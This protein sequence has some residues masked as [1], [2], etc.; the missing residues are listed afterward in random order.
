M[1]IYTCTRTNTS[2]LSPRALCTN[3]KHSSSAQR[4]ASHPIGTHRRS[5]ARSLFVPRPERALDCRARIIALKMAAR[6]VSIH[7]TGE[8]FFML[9]YVL[10][11]A[12]CDAL[13]FF[14][15]RLH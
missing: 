11:A 15:V 12:I 8:M 1:E 10:Q 4:V 9:L 14:R 3:G 13:T 5:L 6:L 2:G 7:H